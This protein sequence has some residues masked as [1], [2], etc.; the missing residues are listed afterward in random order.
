LSITTSEIVP[1][2]E[3]QRE[4]TVTSVDGESMVLSDQPGVLQ[5]VTIVEPAGIEVRG[6]GMTRAAPLPIEFEYRGTV[7]TGFDGINRATC[8]F[9]KLVTTVTVVLTGP[10]S[11]SETFTLGAPGTQVS[12]P[13][14]EGTLSVT[15]REIV[16]P[17]E[18]QREIT[19]TSV[20][21]ESLVISD[22]PGVLQTVTIVEPVVFEIGPCRT[23]LAAQLPIEFEYAGTVPT[24]FDGINTATCTFTRAV[25]TLRVVLTGPA[26]HSETFTLSA[27]STEVSFPLPEGTLSITTL[28]IVPPGEYQREMTVTSVDGETLVIS[29]QPGVLQTVT[30]VEQVVFEVGP[31]LTTLAAQLPIEFVYRGTVPTGFDGINTATCTF[32]KPVETLRV[33][34]RGPATHTEIF[35]LTEPSTA[36]SFPLPEVTLS[37]RTQEIVPPGDYERE[38][39]V[40]AVDGDTLVLSDQPG[41]L[42]TVTV[43]EQAAYNFAFDD[44]AEGWTTG[45]ADLPAVRD[46]SIYELDSGYRALPTGLEGSGIYL[47]GHNRSDDLFMYLTRQVGGLEPNTTYRAVI[48]VHLATNVASGLM[49]IGGSPGDSVYV[50]AGA[51]TDEPSASLDDGGWLRISVDKGNQASEGAEAANLG[52]VGH[53]EV[54]GDEYRIKILSNESHPLE[55][56]SDAEGR[57]W[58]IVGTDSGFEGLTAVYYSEISYVLTR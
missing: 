37:I 50:K 32:T 18:Y 45:F 46:E 30:I 51:T 54:Q 2:G 35:T 41:V 17:G 16:P 27:P 57:L 34:L 29:D 10:T 40:T 19:V 49:G 48:T 8:A 7:P 42:K 13:L 52:V 43:I 33:V 58:L 44:N 4:I 25:E 11:H 23:T 53:P 3:Y 20:D 55:A 47:Q 1:P 9:T 15:T 26:T 38:M 28:E 12:F 22:Q 21:G 31:C 5:T 36:V 14:P 56:T 24:G 6:C 39:T